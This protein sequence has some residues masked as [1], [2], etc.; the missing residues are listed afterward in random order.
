[1]CGAAL[2]EEVQG[3]CTR[4]RS[5][6]VIYVLVRGYC[7]AL[8]GDIIIILNGDLHYARPEYATMICAKKRYSTKPVWLVFELT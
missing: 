3:A 2:Q 6:G 1:M 4:H 7:L 8:L 5:Q